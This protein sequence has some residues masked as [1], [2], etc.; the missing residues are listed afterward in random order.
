MVNKNDCKALYRELK[1]DFGDL[2]SVNFRGHWFARAYRLKELGCWWHH[3]LLIRKA[4]DYL[5]GKGDYSEL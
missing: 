1:E 2:D 5:K 3:A 4:R